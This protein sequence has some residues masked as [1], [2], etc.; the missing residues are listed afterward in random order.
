MSTLSSILTRTL[1]SA[2]VTTAALSGNAIAAGCGGGGCAP[3]RTAAKSGGC[4]ARN[5]KA[6][7]GAC[8][9][10]AGKGKAKGGARCGAK[11]GAKCGASNAGGGAVCAAKK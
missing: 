6:A 11:C 10:K 2:V 8:G 1:A 5:C 9:A 7:C 3:K 4:G